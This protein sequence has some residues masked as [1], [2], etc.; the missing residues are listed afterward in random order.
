M[1]KG[2]FVPI[3]RAPTFEKTTCAAGVV[4]QKYCTFDVPP[5]GTGFATVMLAVPVVATSA[6]G[7]FAVN[8]DALTKVVA[9]ALPFQFTVA[10]ET[11]Q[12][13]F[14]VR[15]NDGLP[16]VTAAGTSGWLRKGTGFDWAPAEAPIN[17]DATREKAAPRME[18]PFRSQRKAK[19]LY[20]SAIFRELT[21]T[22]LYSCEP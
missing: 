7:T 12:V 19:T 16:G 9:R 20:R 5:P 22:A 3:S 11:N 10:P 4:I 13:P 15:V 2:V 18:A 21:L 1:V 14:A 17:R 8:C 6:A